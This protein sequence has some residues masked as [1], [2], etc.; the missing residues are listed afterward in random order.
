MIALSVTFKIFVSSIH[1][2]NTPLIAVN[3]KKEAPPEG[4]A[5]NL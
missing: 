4:G 1:I 5:D 3:S 2:T